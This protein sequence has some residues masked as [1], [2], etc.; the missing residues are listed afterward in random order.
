[1]RSRRS[2]THRWRASPARTDLWSGEGGNFRAW[3][4]SP[5]GRPT[6]R[7]FRLTVVLSALWWLGAF[8]LFDMKGYL[9]WLQE[10]HGNLDCLIS[11]IPLLGLNPR[12]TFGL[13]T[14][15][16]DILA[17]P[18]YAVVLYQAARWVL[19]GCASLLGP[20]M[21]RGVWQF[22]LGTAVALGASFGS[23]VVVAWLIWG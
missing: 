23:G 9:T 11:Y 2:D 13:A 7:L 20:V 3:L 12:V 21:R 8:Y 18:V 17:A 15:R 16:F 14:W 19:G 6:S 5:T 1:M 4:T 10:C 22:G